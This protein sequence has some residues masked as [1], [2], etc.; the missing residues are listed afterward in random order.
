MT[1]TPPCWCSEE[2]AAVLMGRRGYIVATSELR[3]TH[4]YKMVVPTGH[5]HI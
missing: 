2:G 4:A 3:E 5:R 1:S